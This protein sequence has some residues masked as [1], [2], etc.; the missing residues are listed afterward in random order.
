MLKIWSVKKPY[1]TLPLMKQ[2]E[3]V[4]TVNF[5]VNKRNKN[6]QREKNKKGLK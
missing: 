2:V 4:Q 5:F 3:E 6:S 1:E